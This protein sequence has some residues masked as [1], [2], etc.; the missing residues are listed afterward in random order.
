M[1]SV[2]SLNIKET[3]G[4]F[5]KSPFWELIYPAIGE[6]MYKRRVQN[7]SCRRLAEMER[8]YC[9]SDLKVA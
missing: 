5:Q 8:F 2:S 1:L 7:V 6:D 3:D 4:E 9:C